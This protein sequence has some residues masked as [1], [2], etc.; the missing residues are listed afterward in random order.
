LGQWNK[1][2]E[3]GLLDF[4]E[5]SQLG[6]VGNMPKRLHAAH[7]FLKYFET[8]DEKPEQFTVLEFKQ[9]PVNVFMEFNSRS[10]DDRE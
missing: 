7:S 4:P 1:H 8:V 10:D 6:D 3:I 5:C 2:Q 9:C